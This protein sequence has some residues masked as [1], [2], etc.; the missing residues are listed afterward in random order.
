[1][2]TSLPEVDTTMLFLLQPQILSR[3]Q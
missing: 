2:M 3:Q 1:M